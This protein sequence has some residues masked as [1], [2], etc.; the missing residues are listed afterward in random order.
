MLCASAFSALWLFRMN[1][2]RPFPLCC[3]TVHEP[4]DTRIVLEPAPGG[5]SITCGLGLVVSVMLA[6]SLGGALLAMKR[7]LKETGYA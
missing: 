1:I 3:K 6:M 7:A 5:I 2:L 4:D